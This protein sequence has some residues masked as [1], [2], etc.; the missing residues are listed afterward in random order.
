MADE[1]YTAFAGP[2]RLAAGPLPV[3]AAAAQAA[4]AEGRSGVLVFDDSDGTVVELDLRRGPEAAVVEFEGRAAPP[5]PGVRSRGRP[6][7][8]VVAAYVT[9]L[10]QAARSAR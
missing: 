10:A 4:L 3:V 1:T 8:G 9:R 2:Q 6:R 5:P 7:L